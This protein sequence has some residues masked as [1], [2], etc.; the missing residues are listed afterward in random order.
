ME[1]TNKTEIANSLINASNIIVE[2]G[3]LKLKDGSTLKESIS[4]K[5]ISFWTIAETDLALHVLPKLLFSKP[6][7]FNYK[8][9][10][11]LFLRYTKYKLFNLYNLFFF[12]FKNLEKENNKS[13]WFILGFT[14][15]IYRDTLKPIFD[16]IKNRIYNFIK[17]I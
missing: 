4:F 1:D 6:S 8:N 15:Y 11:F 5:G 7:F 17:M 12:N 3:K 9:K 10:L 2:L 14:N 13:I 16:S